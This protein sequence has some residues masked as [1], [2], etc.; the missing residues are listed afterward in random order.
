MAVDLVWVEVSGG[1]GSCRVN[2][3]YVVGQI[4]FACDEIIKIVEN[5]DEDSS[6]T[7]TPS[8]YSNMEKAYHQLNPSVAMDTSNQMDCYLDAI[9]R[10]SMAVANTCQDVSRDR[11]VEACQNVLETR[12]DLTALQNMMASTPDS[13]MS[14]RKFD[15]TTDKLSLG[16]KELDRQVTLSIIEQIN[17]V[18][19]EAERPAKQLLDISTTAYNSENQ[20]QEFME[21]SQKAD[22][23]HKHASKV[24]QISKH[25]ASLSSDTESISSGCRLFVEPIQLSCTSRAPVMR[26]IQAAKNG[27]RDNI[28]KLIKNTICQVT[29]LMG[30]AEKCVEK[31]HNVEQVRQIRVTSGEIE[32]LTPIITQASRDVTANRRDRTAVDRLHVIGREWASKAHVLGDAIDAIVVPWSAAGSKL[33]LAA[34][35]GDTGELK[36]QINNIND[37]AVRLRQLALSAIAAA[38]AEDYAM[39]PGNESDDFER[40]PASF[41]RIK[42]LRATSEETDKVIPELILAAQSLVVNPTDIS[43]LEHLVLLRRVWACNVNNLITAVDDIIVGTSAPVEHLTNAAMVSDNQALQDRIRMVV[44]YTRTLKDMAAAA[45]AGCTNSKKAVLVE[46]TVASIER[47]TADLHDTTRAVVA[48]SA[49]HNKSFE[50]ELAFMSIEEK[51]KLLRREWA[52]K[53]HLL[54]ALVDDLTADVSAPVDRLAG[55]AL[56][57]SKA[58]ISKKPIM[59]REFEFCTR[60]L[61]VVSHCFSASSNY[62]NAFS[63]AFAGNCASGN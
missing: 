4:K 43:R 13:M 11:I 12:N 55:A 54:T 3:D 5:R 17:I 23:F 52:T 53:V 45:T 22:Q 19:G 58:E 1:V 48:L 50:Q 24:V 28:E 51:M 62:T 46:S 39:D 15:K 26:L 10:S 31:S 29:R 8:M 9:V 34:A 42:L 57:V 25:A 63:K 40:N 27:E 18:F 56:A 59:E 61:K 35:C 2:R 20:E 30:L 37:E 32:K 16:L 6:S 47:L 49:I 60:R 21:M 38:D 7:E 41:Q 33:A 36:K 14:R 44:S